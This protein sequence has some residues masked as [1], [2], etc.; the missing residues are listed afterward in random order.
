MWLIGRTVDDLDCS[1]QALAR[2]CRQTTC[3]MNMTEWAQNDWTGPVDLT[4][5][6]PMTT[7]RPRPDYPNIKRSEIGH[8][9]YIGHASSRFPEIMHT[10]GNCDFLSNIPH[11]ICY[12]NRAIKPPSHI[13]GWS[14]VMLLVGPGGG[15]KKSK[16]KMIFNWSKSRCSFWK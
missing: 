7:S 2:C 14:L 1:L 5:V 15:G 9:W 8:I 16:T 10:G 3:H 6:Q 13:K 4:N 11:Q 12:A